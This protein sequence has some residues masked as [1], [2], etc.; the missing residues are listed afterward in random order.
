MGTARG[1]GSGCSKRASVWVQKKGLTV[2]A[3]RGLGSEYSK[4]DSGLQVSLYFLYFLYFL[5][6]PIFSYLIKNSL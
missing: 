1:L 3:T 4:R 2:G 5:T 6:S